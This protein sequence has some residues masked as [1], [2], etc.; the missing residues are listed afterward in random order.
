MDYS[1]RPRKFREHVGTS[2]TRRSNKTSVYAAF[3]IAILFSCCAAFGRDCGSEPKSGDFLSYA[4]EPE[5]NGD[6][7]SINVSGSFRLTGKRSARL[8][9][10][11]EWEGQKDLDHVISGL[12][13]LS[14]G[15]SL[16]ATDRPSMKELVFPIGQIVRFRYRVTRDWTGRIDASSY[17]R[18]MLQPQYFQVTG[19]N[20]LVYP[21]LPPD[22]ELLISLAWTNLPAGWRALSSFGGDSPCYASVSRSVKVWNGLFI[23][24]DLRVSRIDLAGKPV[25]VV[26][27]G[28]WKFE[29]KTFSDMVAGILSSERRFWHDFEAPNYLITVLP[30][31]EAPGNYG[32]VA[33][34][35][36]FAV[37]M[38]PVA[39][40]DFSIK[41]LL[42]H[43]MFHAWNVGRLGEV[44]SDPPYWFS[45]GFTDYYARVL[46]LR[47]GLITES[48]YSADV[49]NA[50]REYLAL[51][52][53]HTSGKAAQD[54]FLADADVQ[55]LL[56]L[57]GDFL[58]LRW[59][60][61]IDSQSRGQQSLDDAMFELLRK[62]RKQE[63]ELTDAYLAAHFD[64]YT[65][66]TASKDM[67]KYIDGGEVIP[68]DP[69]LTPRSDTGSH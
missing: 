47:A 13:I 43:E 41:F 26:T 59:A 27:R 32:G 22:E 30:S 48:E 34:E 18:V 40:L 25:F 46:L 7:L 68:L 5:L 2:R 16:R 37:F 58:A 1:A 69:H 15:A 53:L 38:S 55:R 23:S 21:E 51:P 56:Y 4:I 62:A 52:V 60:D 8:V 9:L 17:F 14:A 61:L 20:F 24:G 64:A 29:D 6:L 31:D 66:K 50:Y 28:K 39:S 3:M 35:D 10:P 54:G 57:R 65:G 12:E 45:E 44:K 19:Q 49:Q 42:A 63:V 33:M 67:Q 11:S 36:S